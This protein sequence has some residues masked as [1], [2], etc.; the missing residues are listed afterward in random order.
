MH[1]KSKIQRSAVAV[2]GLVQE[3]FLL[4]FIYIAV[5]ENNDVFQD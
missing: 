3:L 5:F 1:Q 2:Y 4:F